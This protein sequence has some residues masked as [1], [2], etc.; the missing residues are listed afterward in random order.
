MAE[1]VDIVAPESDQEG[2]EAVMERWFRQVGDFVEQHEPL[3]EIS[4]D[5]VSL[6]PTKCRW[7]FPP[8]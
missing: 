8:R 1:L 3:L 2:T 5:K 7:K 4:T 6:A